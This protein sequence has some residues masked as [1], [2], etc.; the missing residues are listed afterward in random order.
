MKR[1]LPREAPREHLNRPVPAEGNALLRLLAAMKA[2]RQGY[3]GADR[4]ALR[5]GLAMGMSASR[6]SP[7]SRLRG[8]VL[9]RRWTY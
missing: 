8:V 5:L 7:L 2:G 4:R 6:F 1:K 3:G 9:E